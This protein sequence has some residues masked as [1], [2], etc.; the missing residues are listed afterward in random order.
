MSA[1]TA[2]ALLQRATTAD[3]DGAWR[4]IS[5]IRAATV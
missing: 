4:L 3:L 2:E 5:R 1:A